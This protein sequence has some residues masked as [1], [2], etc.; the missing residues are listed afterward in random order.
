MGSYQDESLSRGFV[1]RI[2]F[3][4]LIAVVG[5]SSGFLS[6]SFTSHLERNEHALRVDELTGLIESHRSSLEVRSSVERSLG[7]AIQSA[8]D[9]LEAGAASAADAVKDGASG[10]L[11][12]AGAEI[13]SLLPNSSTILNSLV[14]LVSGG[15]NLSTIVEGLQQP[16]NSL[17]VGLSTGAV[18]GLN[19]SM[20]VSMAKMA[21]AIATN[22]TTG[23]SGLALNLGSGLT[24]ALFEN[25][26][27]SS[28]LVMD[29][30]MPGGLLGG[31][32]GTV[33][34]AVLALAQGLGGGAVMGLKNAA[35]L[36]ITPTV[37]TTATTAMGMATGNASMF[38]TSGIN[39][40]AGNFGQGLLMTATG[41]LGNVQLPSLSSLMATM[42]DM[43]MSIDL[44]ALGS[45]V[46]TGIGQGAVIGFGLQPDATMNVS[47]VGGVALGFTKG[48]VSSFL[49]NGTATK[50]VDTFMA[51]GGIGA[52]LGMSNS[53]TSAPMMIGGIDVSSISVAKVAEGFAVGLVSGAGSSFTSL[54]VIAADTTNFND[55]VQGGATGFGRGLGSE[56]AKI[57]QMILNGA[58]LDM[59]APA[60]TTPSVV[61][62]IP[63]IG[64]P[65]TGT[66]ATLPAASGAAT[67]AQKRGIRTINLKNVKRDSGLQPRQ[68][69]AQ[70]PLP[71]V[72]DLAGVLNNLNASAINPLT[73][74]GIDTLTCTG[75]GG[76]VGVGFGLFQS[77]AISAGNT[78]IQDLLKSMS[79]M[80][81]FMIGGQNISLPDTTF[82]LKNEGNTY[83]LNPSQ[84]VMTV[85]VNGNPVIKTVILAVLHS[86]SS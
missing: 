12:N 77:G 32:T 82:V 36:A 25:I 49:I 35:I 47:G 54:K 63:A 39:G 80:P 70:S 7:D 61:P 26:N 85:M 50:I 76:L 84:G 9:T 22:Q 41:S 30:N 67:I 5:L 48:L 19:I 38:N 64:S 68:D 10:L 6:Y 46:G 45:G 75:I 58:T 71:S 24:S 40:V 69:A 20:P 8:G 37:A 44:Q 3:L 65:V 66:P 16:A 79:G 53:S 13:S 55:S 42:G 14:S 73:Q 1:G 28:L 62:A 17:G 74:M 60:G 4:I 72:T 83:M 15:G 81:G 56:G 31:S 78:S 33:G 2:G 18:T 11:D 86:K 21:E 43:T 57:A 51:S 34:Q 59:G 23:L 27:V 29:P 52:L